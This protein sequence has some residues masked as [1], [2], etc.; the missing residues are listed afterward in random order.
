MIELESK[1]LDKV[2]SSIDNDMEVPFNVKP[3]IWGGL[4]LFSSFN[5]IIFFI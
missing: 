3:Y 2:K 5:I 4:F 1:I